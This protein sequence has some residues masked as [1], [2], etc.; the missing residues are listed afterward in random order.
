MA[1]HRFQST[2]LIRGATWVLSANYNAQ[3]ISIHAP[4]TRG[5]RTS[6]TRATFGMISI[7]APHTRGDCAHGFYRGGD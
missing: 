7:H 1:V 2:P 6:F 4:H 3:I 5:D